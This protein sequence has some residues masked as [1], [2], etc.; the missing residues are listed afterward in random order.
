M[1]VWGI[2][3]IIALT[4]ILIIFIVL[5][6]LTT[7]N[8]QTLSKAQIITPFSA[9]IDPTTGN[10]SAFT[11]PDGSPQIICPIGTKVNII[12][13]FFD[14]F[15][16]Y[17]E[18]GMKAEDANPLYSFM[19]APSI[20][21][22]KK[23]CTS[24]SDCPFYVENLGAG[25]ANA[26]M[27]NSNNSCQLRQQPVGTRTCAYSG[28]TPHTILGASGSNIYC[29]D[30]NMCGNN[31]DLSIANQSAGVPN[32]YCTPKNANARCAMRDA[33]ASVGSKCDGKQDCATLS[34][35]DFGDFPCSGLQPRQCIINY[36]GNGNPNWKPAVG[37]FKSLVG[38]R[39][40]YCGLPYL[41][42]YGGGV[43][44]NGSGSSVSQNSNLGYTMHGIYTCVPDA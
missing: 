8:N 2:I 17:G 34:M 32:P 43:P 36:D 7:R 19:C 28:L 18:C 26:M 15:D 27:C 40:D 33:S 23:S 14:I 13:A 35:E 22:S 31:I 29:V 21:N 16:P 12:A 9:S 4:I 39:N 5:N 41:A 42:G 3:A 10:A 30:T 44:P 1:A 20:E 37:D 11:K 24:D 25:Q 38:V 6:A